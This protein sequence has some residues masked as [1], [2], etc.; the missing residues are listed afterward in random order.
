MSKNVSKTKKR[1]GR[2]PLATEA[3]RMASMGFRPT[4]FVRRQLEAAAA[5]S[6]RSLS[7]E[8]ESHL[9]V[10]FQS[11]EREVGGRRNL[12]LLRAIGLLVRTVETMTDGT[13]D[14]D[15]FTFE[16]V[17]QAI[18]TFLDAM[19]PESGRVDRVSLMDEEQQEVKDQLGRHVA[20]I[21]AKRIAQANELTW[22][23]NSSYPSDEKKLASE[24]NPILGPL[25]RDHSR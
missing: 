7:Q 23:R 4:P 9:E 2:P 20:E 13:W 17:K 18:D 3:K 21:C 8:I 22:E 1:V 10:S 6:G 14:D 15:N 11:E 24:L 25:L 12:A 16:H 19:R 5:V